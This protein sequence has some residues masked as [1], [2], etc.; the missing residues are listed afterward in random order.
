VGSGDFNRYVDLALLA[1]QSVVLLAITAVV[2]FKF[3]IYLT[4]L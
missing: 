1:I 2:I 3:A 4:N